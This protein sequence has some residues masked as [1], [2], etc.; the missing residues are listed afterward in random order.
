M[1]DRLAIS[2]LQVIGSELAI[3]WSDGRE[4]YFELETLR[5]ACPCAACA[6]EPDGVIAMA[7]P[8]VLYNDRSFALR[9]I[10]RVGGYAIQPLWEDGHQTGLYSYDFLRALPMNPPNPAP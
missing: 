7:K 2:Q 10:D 5:R 9:R 4:Q 8:Q 1:S 6:G 3:A